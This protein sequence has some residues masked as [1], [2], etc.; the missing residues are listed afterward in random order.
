MQSRNIFYRGDAAIWEMGLIN[1]MEPKAWNI[2]NEI[3]QM[4]STKLYNKHKL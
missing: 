4:K 1:Y 2:Q 3:A